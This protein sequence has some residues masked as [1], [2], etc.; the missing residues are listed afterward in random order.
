MDGCYGDILHSREDILI[1]DALFFS[2]VSLKFWSSVGAW[3]RLFF[4]TND[5]KFLIETMIT[6]VGWCCRRVY[7]SLKLSIFF[8]VWTLCGVCHFTNSQYQS[9]LLLFC[10]VLH[11][12][13]CT[14]LQAHWKQGI[15]C[16]CMQLSGLLFNG[17]TCRK[18][19]MATSKLINAN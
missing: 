19:E 6:F 10:F 2:C 3:S 13:S 18:K 15:V 12:L 4:L 17:I 1:T 5:D 7:I 14:S 16:R 11:L 9:L 8:S